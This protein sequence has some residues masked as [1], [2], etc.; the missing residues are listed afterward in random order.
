MASLALWALAWVLVH[1]VTGHRTPQR[2]GKLALSLAAGISLIA[3]VA[4]LPSGLHLQKVVARLLMPAGLL[5]LLGLALLGFALRQGARR[6]A[7]AVGLFWAA[8]WALSCPRLSHL[9]LRSLEAPFLRTNPFEGPPLEAVAV[10][11][12]G[13]APF[14]SRLGPSGDRVVLAAQLLH[15]GRTQ[16]VVVTGSS[17]SGIGPHRSLARETADVLERLAVSTSSIV[18]LEGDRNTSEE[19]AAL[20]TWWDAQEAPGPLGLIT[21]AWHLPRALHLARRA[22]L[23]VEPLPADLRSRELGWGLLDVLPDAEALFVMHR[24]AWE[25]LGRAVGR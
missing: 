9:A 21:S 12:G 24:A 18:R 19:I 8:F 13:T 10:L 7:L 17:I 2:K 5:W 1:H 20:K 4:L 23:E 25:Y 16:Q 15:A 6:P 3:G 14:P 22:G 11:G